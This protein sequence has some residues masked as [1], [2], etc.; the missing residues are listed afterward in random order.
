MGFDPDGAAILET[1]V[2]DFVDEIV[3]VEL[4][5]AKRHVNHQPSR[6]RRSS[7][8]LELLAEASALGS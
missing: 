5:A 8:M 7:T 1:Q 3:T 6:N 2:E 4:T